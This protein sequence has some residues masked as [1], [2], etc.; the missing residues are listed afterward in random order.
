MQRQIGR[1]VESKRSGQSTSLASVPHR[2]H[3]AGELIRADEDGAAH[4]LLA[5][6]A[7]HDGAAAF[8]EGELERRLPAVAVRYVDI[9]PAAR[10]GHVDEAAP[11]SATGGL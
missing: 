5:A 1:E 9:G 10:G 4:G 8:G 7:Q 6:G 11:G 3:A 2:D